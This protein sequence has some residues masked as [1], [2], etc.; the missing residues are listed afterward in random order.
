MCLLDTGCDV[1]L[2]PHSIVNGI[3]INEAHQKLRAANGTSIR[4]LGTA[5]IEA[6]MGDHRMI[7]ALS[8]TIFLT[9]S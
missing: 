3:Q 5:T 9:S 8:Q 4:V 1:T 7:L 6:H 2:L